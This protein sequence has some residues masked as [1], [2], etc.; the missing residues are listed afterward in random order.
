MVNRAMLLAQL[1][2]D[3]LEK[4]KFK[5]QKQPYPLRKGSLMSRMGLV[6]WIS[7]KRGNYE[8]IGVYMVFVS[9]VEKSMK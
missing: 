9:L 4:S 7:P 1:H 3:V 5:P 8:I 6:D 2:Q